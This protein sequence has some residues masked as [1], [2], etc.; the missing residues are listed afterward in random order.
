MTRWVVVETHTL[1]LRSTR[2]KD[3]SLSVMTRK[4][5]WQS[6]AFRKIIILSA[7]A[8]KCSQQESANAP[9]LSLGTTVSLLGMDCQKISRLRLSNQPLAYREG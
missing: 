1:H 9:L 3:T 6:I 4:E 8:G 5:G 7:Q 2:A